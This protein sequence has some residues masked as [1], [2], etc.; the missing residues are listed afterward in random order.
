V[1]FE[2]SL[3]IIALVTMGRWMEGKAKK[4]TA[5]AIKALVGLTPKTARVLRDG[6]EVDIP[7]ED[8]VEIVPRARVIVVRDLPEG[9][10]SEPPRGRGVVSQ[11]LSWLRPSG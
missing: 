4:Q 2:T 7:V 6:T 8:V 3:V 5:S 11:A 10:D 9:H 1:Y